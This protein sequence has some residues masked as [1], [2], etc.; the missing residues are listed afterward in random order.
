MKSNQSRVKETRKLIESCG[1]QI[2]E[3][4]T[5][6]GNHN[7]FKLQRADGKTFVFVSAVSAS[8]VRA[9]LNNRAI[10]RRFAKGLTP[11]GTT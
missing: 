9:E 2:V 1:L 8:D 7:R 5:S 4:T 6:G 10:L 3:H 11:G